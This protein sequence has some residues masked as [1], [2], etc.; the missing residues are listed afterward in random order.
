M[1]SSNNWLTALWFR[2]NSIFPS[3][4]FAYL[5]LMSAILSLVAGALHRFFFTI[6][7]L[8][9]AL[10]V[11]AALDFFSLPKKDAFSVHRHVN[12]LQQ[13][14]PTTVTLSLMNTRLLP[15]WIARQHAWLTDDLSY[16]LEKSSDIISCQLTVFPITIHYLVIPKKRGVVHFGAVH[17]RIH[18]AWGLW[19]RQYRFSLDQEKTVWPNL[20]LSSA[21]RQVLEQALH[22]EGNFLHRVGSGN[23]DFAMIRDFTNGDDPRSIN[24]FATARKGTLM[25]NTYQPEQNQHILFAIDCGRQMGIALHDFTTKLDYAIEA[26][27]ISA[28]VAIARGDHVSIIAFSDHLWFH[29]KDIRSQQALSDVQKELVHLQA[30]PVYTGFHLLSQVMT[31]SQQPHTFICFFS[32]FTDF[33]SSDLMMKQAIYLSKYHT[34]TLISFRDQALEKALFSPKK[35]NSARLAEQ[36][37]IAKLL[38][39]RMKLQKTLRSHGIETIETTDHLF[40]AAI[41]AYLR[42]K[43]QKS[44]TL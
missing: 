43:N 36:G 8:A 44:L 37:A 1:R 17:L 29:K 9:I 5:F 31:Q 21:K 2:V 12:R 14:E 25:R 33:V 13:N 42:Y 11:M 15:R 41:S 34:F 3:T 19:H 16:T 22:D 38:H 35:I 39:D 32:D 30:E 23:A 6:V 7:F 27:M 20:I 4:R 10:V 18:S 24:W 28:Q 40:E 26:T